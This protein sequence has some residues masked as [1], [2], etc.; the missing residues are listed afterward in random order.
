MEKQQLTQKG[1]SRDMPKFSHPSGSDTEHDP[2][3]LAAIQASLHDHHE[4]QQRQQEQQRQQQQQEQQQQ[5]VAQ[6]EA[7]IVSKHPLIQ[8]G[9]LPGLA[10]R[11]V[12]IVF[13]AMYS[14]TYL[15]SNVTFTCLMLA[16]QLQRLRARLS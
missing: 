12:Q 15:F 3:L 16:K 6:M 1:K 14:F 8:S 4:H 10:L 5:Q 11:F 7:T 13:S 2:D 9:Q